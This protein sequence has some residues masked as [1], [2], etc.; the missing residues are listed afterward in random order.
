[1]K[2]NVGAGG[3]DLDGWINTDVDVAAAYVPGSDQGLGP[4]RP[5]VS[6]GYTPTTWWNIFRCRYAERFF[7]IAGKR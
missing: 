5:E 7:A 3:V 4:C 2:V 6:I 1:M